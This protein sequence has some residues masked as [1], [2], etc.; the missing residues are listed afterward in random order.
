MPFQQTNTAP[1]KL[2]NTCKNIADQSTC[3]KTLDRAN[4][5][6]ATCFY[7]R[8]ETP[9]TASYEKCEDWLKRRDQLRNN[10]GQFTSP[11]KNADK[12]TDLNLSIKSHD[13]FECYNKSEGKPVHTNIDDELCFRP[14]ENNL[15]TEQG[16][17]KEK[18]RTTKPTE[19]V[20]RSI[21]LPFA[22]QTK[23]LGGLPYFTN[24]NNKKSLVIYYR[25]QQ[26]K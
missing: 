10:K 25:K 20:R 9:K 1:T 24:N 15:T 3:S 22:E 23:K 2:I 19:S 7:C 21:R 18:N 12:N 5:G 8:K 14:K 4:I 11:N 13:E 17:H 16:R 26:W 6:G